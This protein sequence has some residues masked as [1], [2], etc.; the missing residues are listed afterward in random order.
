MGARQFFHSRPG[1][2]F[3][4]Y[5]RAAYP[6]DPNRPVPVRLASAEHLRDENPVLSEWTLITAR[7]RTKQLFPVRCDT[8]RLGRPLMPGST[9]SQGAIQGD[10]EGS[11]G[12]QQIPLNL[13]LAATSC[14]HQVQPEN[15]LQ[16][17]RSSTYC[18]G[19]SKMGFRS[20]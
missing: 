11:T 4:G 20:G 12:P 3:A 19:A 9:P 15:D 14:S 2:G 17:S 1:R 13:S 7:F 10:R 6:R 5:P 18:R 8:A 16:R